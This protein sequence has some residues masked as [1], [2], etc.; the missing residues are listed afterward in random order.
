MDAITL[1]RDIPVLGGRSTT[2]R[3]RSLALGFEPD[4]CWWIQRERQLRGVRHYDPALHPPPDLVVEVEVS[5]SAIDT[6][7]LFAAF[8]VAEVWRHDGDRLVVHVRDDRGRM[9]EQATSRCLP[10]LPIDEFAQRIAAGLDAPEMAWARALG[11]WARTLPPASS[12]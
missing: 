10:F 7:R 5:R 9:R 6:L 12:A 2:F 4:E 8:G 11:E 3:R 1:A